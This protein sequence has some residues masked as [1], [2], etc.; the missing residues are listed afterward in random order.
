MS[1]PLVGMYQQMMRRSNCL[2]VRCA[3]YRGGVENSNEKQFPGRWGHP[4]K[5]FPG[6]KTLFG[7]N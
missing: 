4:S 6:P 5:Q 2:I 1:P 7:R 3:D